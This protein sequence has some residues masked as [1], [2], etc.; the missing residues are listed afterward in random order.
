MLTETSARSLECWFG[1]TS[2]FSRLFIQNMMIKFCCCFQSG[3][4]ITV[5]IVIGPRDG[6]S[7]KAEQGSVVRKI[8]KRLHSAMSTIGKRRPVFYLF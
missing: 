7:Y 6:I 1:W 2:Y 3:W 4:T 8:L 5:D